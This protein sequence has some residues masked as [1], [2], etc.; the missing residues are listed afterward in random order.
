VEKEAVNQINKL[1]G[2][3]AIF[4]SSKMDNVDSVRPKGLPGFYFPLVIGIILVEFAAL[5]YALNSIL[6][7]HTLVIYPTAAYFSYISNT[8]L[9]QTSVIVTKWFFFFLTAGVMIPTTLII[10]AEMTRR[11]IIARR[12]E[13]DPW[14]DDANSWLDK[15]DKPWTSPKASR[16]TVEGDYIRR[17]DIHARIQ[18]I[19]LMASFI[20]LAITGL[21][22]GFPAWPTFQF[23]TALF[24]GSEILRYVHDGAAFVMFFDCI[25]HIIYIGYGYFVQHKFPYAMLP[26]LKDL[27]DLIHTFLWI[28]GQHKHEPKY[29]RYQ[30]GQKI[31]YWAIFWGMPV[32]GLTGLV[33]MFPAF[34]SH[35]FPGQVFAVTAAAHR[36]EAIL[37]TF[38]ILI[39][40]MYYGHLATIAFPI[41]TVIFT[42]RMLKSKYKQWFGRE[43]A[44][45]TGETEKEG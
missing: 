31:D 17:F 18:H 27:K 32:M 39:V 9:T 41:N 30:Y 2:P 22:R 25:Y 13:E 42:G 16:A 5:L 45:I 8:D 3:G 12:G 36:D 10:C 29:E 1:D 26:S 7:I 40:H 21:L 19:L 28:F 23:W 43:Y 15:L 6:P 14:H 4:D 35:W 37:A 38:F 24:G 20:I 34:F 11:V 44:Q 33:M